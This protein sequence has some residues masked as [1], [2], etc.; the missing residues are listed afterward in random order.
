MLIMI[1][2]LVLCFDYLRFYNLDLK[3]DIYVYIGIQ[4]G[5]KNCG[6][7]YGRNFQVRKY[8]FINVHN[9]DIQ[10]IWGYTTISVK[11]LYCTGPVD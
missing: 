4:Q 10:S 6:L 11:L 1:A 5:C 7:K 2:S 9:H 3:I 8:S